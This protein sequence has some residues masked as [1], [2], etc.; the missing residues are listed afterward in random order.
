[1]LSVKPLLKF[2]LLHLILN[3]LSTLNILKSSYQ[4][5]RNHHKELN[6]LAFSYFKQTNRPKTDTTRELINKLLNF[7]DILFKV[8]LFKRSLY[9]QRKSLVTVKIDNWWP[10]NC[11]DLINQFPRKMWLIPNIWTLYFFLITILCFYLISVFG[12]LIISNQK[13]PKI[14]SFVFLKCYLLISF[15]FLTISFLNF[16]SGKLFPTSMELTQMVT[17]TVTMICSWRESTFTTLK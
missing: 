5:I 15:V 13:S 1:M 3:N 14:T 2:N 4:V 16:S 8:L 6:I 7:F 17:I 10:Q 11:S 12:N 9:F